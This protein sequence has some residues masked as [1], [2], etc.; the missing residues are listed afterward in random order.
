[1]KLE[2]VSQIFIGVLTSRELT[3]FGEYEYKVFSIKSYDSQEEYEI[4]KSEKKLD[5]KLTKEGDILIRLIYPNR[6]IYIDEKLENLL[7]PSQMCIIRVD[8]KKFDSKFLRWY[9]ESDIGKEKILQEITG[10]SIQKISV[11]SLRKLDIPE[12]DIEKQKT[13]VDL[14]ALWNNEKEI[15]QKTILSKEILYNSL[16]EEI[17]E[18]EGLY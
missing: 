4:V 5:D 16:I 15:L 13:I 7:V 18:K 1:M 6:I 9:L 3:N 10:S 8:D 17:I 11:A 2:D 14:L 12:L